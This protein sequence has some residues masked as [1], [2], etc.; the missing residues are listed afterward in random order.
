MTWIKVALAILI[1]LAIAIAAVP[2]AVLFDLARGGTGLGLCPGGVARC[3]N[4][5]SAAPELS[6]AL[7]VALFVVVAG[8]RLLVKTARQAER[9]RR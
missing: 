1:A 8:L 7:T 2:L 3:H 6:V 9:N 4:P 5:Y